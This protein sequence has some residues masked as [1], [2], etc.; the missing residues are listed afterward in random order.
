MQFS[1][2]QSAPTSGAGKPDSG[3]AFENFA[4]KLLR[5]ELRSALISTW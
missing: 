3:W 4:Q 1:A 2:R 5:D